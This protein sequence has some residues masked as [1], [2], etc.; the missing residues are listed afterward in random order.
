MALQEQAI[1]RVAGRI[2]RSIRDETGTRTVFLIQGRDTIVD[3]E[4]C[5]SYPKIAA[6]DDQLVR[7]IDGLTRSR[8]KSLRRKMELAGQM[9]LFTAAQ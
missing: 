6:V 8:N 9:D 4:S 2:V 3:L 5:K 1:S 7:Q